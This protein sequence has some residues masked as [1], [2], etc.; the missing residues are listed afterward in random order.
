MN[1]IIDS[2]DFWIGTVCNNWRLL[3][4]QLCKNIV[5]SKFL[6]YVQQLLFIDILYLALI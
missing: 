6:V 4:I 1:V 5:F 3:F 2:L